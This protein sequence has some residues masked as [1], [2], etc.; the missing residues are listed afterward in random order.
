MHLP[1]FEFD[2]A[3]TVAQACG[4]LSEYG[5]RAQVIAGG[6]DLT[7]AMKK[8]RPAP[9]RL[10]S[11]AGLPELQGID[12]SATLLQIGSC[13]T[14]AA[15]AASGRIARRWGAICA[16]AQA[17]GSPSVRN[18]ATVGGNL[19]GTRPA[20]DMP[21][22]LMAYG[23]RVVLRG[24]SGER[25]VSLDKFFRGPGL[26]V[27]APEEILTE[28]RVDGPPPFSG[29]AYSNIGLRSSCDCNIVNVASFLG[30]EGPGAVIAE[31]RIALG[32]VGPTP[33][34]AILAER[35]LIGQR[36]CESLFERAAQAATR[37]CSP[38]DDFRGSADYRKDMVRALTRKTLAAACQEA[39]RG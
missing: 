11:I 8:G 34:R 2:E 32:C 1:R 15:I 3:A 5:A 30:L 24:A 21:P 17:L 39:L 37:D 33:R 16:G 29:A 14:I 25:V 38:I 4:M 9:E 36:A 22:A 7:V 10:I 31:A 12:A 18:H 26:T 13:V 23:A 20:A 19:C 35:A 27:I 28:I 6:T